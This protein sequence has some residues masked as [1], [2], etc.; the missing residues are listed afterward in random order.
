MRF[1]NR[2]CGDLQPNDFSIQAEKQRAE[3]R[4]ILDLTVS[5]PTLAGF[6]YP[7]EEIRAALAEGAG[8]PYEPDPRGLA[9]A[10]N[11]VSDYYRA[12]GCTVPPERIVLTSGTSEAYAFLLKI[13]CSPG[14][15]VLFPRPSYPLVELIADL[16]GTAA[17]AY[18]LAGEN[19]RYDT[20]YL[21]RS[22]E[23][24]ARAVVAVSPNNP[25]GTMLTV[26]ELAAFNRF[27]AGH[28]LAMIV[29]E[30]FLDYPAAGRESGVV[31]SAANSEALTFTLGG[32]SKACGLPQMKLAWIAVSGPERDTKEALERLEFVADAFLSVGTPVQQAA[33]SL[34]GLGAAIREQIR[35]RID[36]NEHF[37]QSKAGL[38]VLPR[39]GGWYSVIGL[40]PGTDDEEFALRLLAEQDVIVQPGFLFDFDDAQ[41]AV[42]SLLAPEKDF[43]EGVRRI[44]QSLTGR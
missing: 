26:E 23:A 17:R 9:A 12:R 42:I 22:F 38:R 6:R 8:Y 36:Q 21:E 33:P 16:E 3:G 14:E 27:C 7:Q 32:L 25:N 18:P 41:T 35:R 24:G 5:N 37:L 34:L 28:G 20:D 15:A 30:V 10:R 19:L 44:L 11:A 4:P 2:I 40:P 29:D 1:S 39:D 43:A 31:S 13:L